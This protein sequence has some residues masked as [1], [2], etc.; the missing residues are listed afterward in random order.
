MADPF[1]N[2]K[3]RFMKAKKTSDRGP[4]NNLVIDFTVDDAIKAAEYLKTK[5]NEAKMDGSTVR[6]YSKPG[7][8]EEVDGFSVWGSMWRDPS[9]QSS[10]GKIAPI[11]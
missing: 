8:Y 1:F 7:E 11:K 6:I 3:F 2:A 5:A 9:D 10:I 4:D